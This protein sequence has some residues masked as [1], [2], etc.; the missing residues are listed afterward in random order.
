MKSFETGNLI[1]DKLYNYALHKN[2]N[3]ILSFIEEFK[4]KQLGGQNRENFKVK[5][6]NL[7]TEIFNKIKDILNTDE[8]KTY[9]VK[10]FVYNKIKSENPTL[11]GLDRAN[12]I[13][14]YITKDTLAEI[15]IDA[16]CAEMEKNKPSNKTNDL[17]TEMVQKIMKILNCSE[18]DAKKYKS[19]FYRKIQN[20]QPE[21]K[22]YDRAMEVLRIITPSELNKLV[23]QN[24]LKT[25]TDS[26]E[27]VEPK[28]KPKPKSKGKN[29]NYLN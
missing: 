5:I 4:L 1:L 11:N 2:Q 3:N 25:L 10:H 9:C 13:L 8:K 23:K 16:A 12:A 21:L 20:E 28:Q 15:D 19:Y 26:K 29:N 22:S 24:F 6:D 7:H 14:N 27:T 17:H 18:D